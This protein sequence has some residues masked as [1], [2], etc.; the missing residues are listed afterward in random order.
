MPRAATARFASPGLKAIRKERDLTQR[1]LGERIGVSREN[2]STIERSHHAVSLDRQRGIVAALTCCIG[3]VFIVE[4][5]DLLT[6]AEV[7]DLIDRDP[8]TITSW[9]GRGV[10][11]GERLPSGDYAIDARHVLQEA[12]QRGRDFRT[13]RKLERD[14]EI[15]RHGLLG[16][17]ERHGLNF[18]PGLGRS[19]LIEWSDIEDL[20]ARLERA[21]APCRHCGEPLDSLTA[22]FHPGCVHMLASEGTRD[23]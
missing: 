22:R 21:P 14:T 6:I 7:V 4:R 12:I 23:W 19:T 15:E 1:Q 5:R 20:I 18:Y 16:L 9:V 3:D 17:A 2:Y 13:L 8:Q 11:L 10:F